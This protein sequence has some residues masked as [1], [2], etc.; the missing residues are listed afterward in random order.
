MK[1]IAVAN[2]KGGCGKTTTTVNLAAAFARMNKR[3]LAIDFDPQGH[4]ALGLGY[5]LSDAGHGIY[6]ALTNMQI[7]ISRVIRRTYIPGVY[8]APSNILLSGVETELAMRPSREYVLRQLLA[9]LGDSYDLCLID[10]SPS[11]GLLTLNALVASDEVLIPVQT[12]YYAI[13][14]LKQ[15]LETVDIVK[16]RFNPA[17]QISGMLLTFVEN[18]TLLSRDVQRQLRESFGEMVFDTMIHRNVRLAEAPSAGESV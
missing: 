15:L 2:Q 10:C 14:G 1:V 5:N 17:L 13:E 3:V 8:L 7:P 16:G 12:H 6:D 4:A 18:R 11:L 9:D